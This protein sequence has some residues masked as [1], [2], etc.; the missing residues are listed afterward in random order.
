MSLGMFYSLASYF[1]VMRFTN[2]CEV[3]RLSHL[4][5]IQLTSLDLR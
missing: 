2:I 5:C 1:S 4:S 3:N